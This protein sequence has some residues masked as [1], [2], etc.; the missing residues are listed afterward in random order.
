MIGPHSQIRKGAGYWR[1]NRG[2]G[3]NLHGMTRSHLI[4]KATT[5]KVY[6]CVCVALGLLVKAEVLQTCKK[7]R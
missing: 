4:F 1:E 5:A 3:V 6:V 7:K 2:G